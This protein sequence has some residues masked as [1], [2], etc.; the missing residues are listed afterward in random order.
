MRSA[1]FCDITQRCVVT[2]SHVSGQLIGPIFKVK[3]STKKAFL[4][5]LILEDGIDKLYR[6]VG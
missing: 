1:L 3:K 4:D 6:N 5:F 2:L